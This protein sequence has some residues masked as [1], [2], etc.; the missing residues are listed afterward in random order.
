MIALGRHAGLDVVCELTDMDQPLGQAV[1]HALEVREA[2]AT[3]RGEGPADLEE[4]VIESCAHLLEL[5]DLGV[6]LGEA[7]RQARQ[8]IADGSGVEAYERWIRA[9]G[10]DPDESALPKAHSIAEAFAPAGGYVQ[11]LSAI[12]VG[13]EALHLGAGR[14]TKDAAIDHAV[15]I[16]CKKKR[17]DVV[18]EGEPVAEV[19][20]RDAQTA[21]DAAERIRAAYVIGDEPPRAVPIV[22]QT[23]A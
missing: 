18:E 17:G 3:L 12:E 16:V 6:D 19:H 15:G 14:A 13:L 5:S 22:L 23:L 2:L 21:A 8:A 10:G 11:R 4:L 20:A 7:R 9:Q 1:G